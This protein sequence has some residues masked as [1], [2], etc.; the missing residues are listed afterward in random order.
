MQAI[1][2]KGVVHAADSSFAAFVAKRSGQPVQQCY[3]CLKCTTGCPVTF[4]MDYMPNQVVRLVQLGFK[5]Q[6]LCSS[7]IWLCASCLTCAARC[8]N[9]IDLV[10]VMDTLHA[11]ALW[12]RRKVKER[13]IRVFHSTMLATVRQLGRVYEPALMVFYKLRSGQIFSDLRLGLRMM[14]KRKLLL[15]PHSIKDRRS[16]RQIFHRIAARRDREASA[17]T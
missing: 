16:V 15:F 1:A 10:R 9:E 5:E 7:T 6:V 12:E 13:S 11:T 3:Q 2:A 17:G 14:L 8:P 4:A